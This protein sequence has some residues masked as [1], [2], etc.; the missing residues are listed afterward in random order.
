MVGGGVAS[1][2]TSGI[3]TH[4][5]LSPGKPIT[6]K[7]VPILEDVSPA[8]FGDQHRVETLITKLDKASLMD[9]HD[10][11]LEVLVEAVTIPWSRQTTSSVDLRLKRCAL[12]GGE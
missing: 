1:T 3:E 6:R 12:L 4:N 2:P 8:F 5:C 10:E 7:H 11:H 9:G